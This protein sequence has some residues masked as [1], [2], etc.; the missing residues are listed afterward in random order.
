MWDYLF[1]PNPNNPPSNKESPYKLNYL[2]TERLNA[3]SRSNSSLREVAARLMWHQLQSVTPL[4][5]VRSGTPITKE[6]HC[7]ISREPNI[8]FTGVYAPFCAS[9]VARPIA[10]FAPLGDLHRRTSPT[11]TTKFG[12]WL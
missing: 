12:A 9:G 6:H 2:H 1:D 7:Q 4:H 8:S 3:P 11:H 10:P 5:R